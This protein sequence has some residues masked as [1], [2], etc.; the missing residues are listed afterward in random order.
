MTKKE[1]LE[2][3][4]AR[5]SPEERRLLAAGE[6]LVISEHNRAAAL[7]LLEASAPEGEV[8]EGEIA[9]LEE[10]LTGYLA[11]MLPEKP[12][13]WK[14]IILG[15]VYLSYIARRPMH[16]IER[17]GIQ[18]RT[19]GGETVYFCPLRTPEADTACH[20]CVCRPLGETQA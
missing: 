8:P 17:A 7:E 14:W 13:A 16:P 20:F 1:L 19:E 11:E 9:R 18:V 12:E 4:R 2:G 6:G 10:I 3:L 5:I 15:C